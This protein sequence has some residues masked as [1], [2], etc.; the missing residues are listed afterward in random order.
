MGRSRGRLAEEKKSEKGVSVET[1]RDLIT[2]RWMKVAEEKRQ[3]GLGWNYGH[4]R[5][6][7]DVRDVRVRP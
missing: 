2:M 4:G 1:K 7:R 3:V 5:R 6:G